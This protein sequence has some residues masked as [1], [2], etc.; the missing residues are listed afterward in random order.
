ML[1][2]YNK[3]GA[4][5]FDVPSANDWIDYFVFPIISDRVN[6]ELNKIQNSLSLISNKLYTS[7]MI[8]FHNIQ[9]YLF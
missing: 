6:N 7:E 1:K 3:F 8:I 9:L 2:K 5:R 4:K